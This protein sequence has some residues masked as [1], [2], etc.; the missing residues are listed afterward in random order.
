M[1][2]QLISTKATHINMSQGV[3]EQGMS[4]SVN[5]L[6]SDDLS[7]NLFCIDFDLTC[8]HRENY[9]FHIIY[10]ASFQTDSE[11]T[12]DF[13]KSDFIRVNAPAIAYPFLR[14]FL[15]NI[16]LNSGFD[17]LLLPSINFTTFK[18]TT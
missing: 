4:L 13:K 1:K 3:A 2:L 11:L 16:M 8:Q 5:P 10:R 18:N 14:A 6:F 7:E 15:A 12:D 9:I 17:P